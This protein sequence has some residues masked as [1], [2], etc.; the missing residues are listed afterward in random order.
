[1]RAKK[2][3]GQHFL[4]SE[5]IARRI[6]QSLKQIGQSYH[7]IVEVGPGKGMLT[8]F[9]T[10]SEAQL[11]LVEADTDMVVYLN[12]HYP[13]LR[14]RIIEAD[15]LKIDLR[16]VLQDQAFALIGNYPYNISSQILIKM[17]ENRA[18]IPEMVGM[19]QKEVAE[20]VVSPPGTKDYGVISVLV[21]AYYRGEYLFS[22]DK[23]KFNPP[24]KVQSGVIRLTRLE[25][26]H[27]DCDEKLFKK[28]VKQAFSQRRKMLRNT[29]KV[30]L[31]EDPVLAEPFFEQRPERLSVGDF[32]NLTKLV[33]K[34]NSAEEG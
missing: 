24:P 32:V 4:N 21:Q 2:S 3:F 28:V 13:D 9:L 12:E 1:M 26:Q 17:V 11:W 7:H 23:S 22:V 10:E 19:F 25:N 8:R 27:L 16:Q 34:A 18:F 30:Y 15:F 5:S 31:K 20:R 33:E 29:M 14:K 6:A